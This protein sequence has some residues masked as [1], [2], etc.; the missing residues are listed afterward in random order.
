MVAKSETMNPNQKLMIVTMLITAFIFSVSFGTLYVQTHIMEGTACSCTLPIPLLIPTFSSFGLFI[1]ALTYYLL[2]P[3]IESKK[4]KVFQTFEAFLS[5]LPKDEA[6]VIKRMI[7]N[8]GEILQS[9]ISSELGKVRSF[10]AIESL[11]RRGLII[12]E[13]YGKTNNLKLSESIIKLVE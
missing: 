11:K 12:K 6:L 9:R 4:E 2:S 10:R 1:G 13:P 5:F 8:K 3:K 7:Q